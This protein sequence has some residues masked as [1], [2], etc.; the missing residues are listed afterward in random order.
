MFNPIHKEITEDQRRRARELYSFKALKGS[1][2]KGSNNIFGALGEILILDHYIKLGVKIE[3]AQ[4]YDYDFLIGGRKVD[5]KSKKH[6]K[7]RLPREDWR[8]NIP[9]YN[10]K[11][12][13]EFYFWVHICEELKEAFLIGYIKKEKFFKDARFCKKGEYD[14]NGYN[15][16]ADCYTSKMSILSPFKRAPL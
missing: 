14:R 1:I 16:R 9:A 3:H 8:V 13:T 7:G 2:T 5:V 4:H 12:R 15:F 10:T 11:Q 6:L